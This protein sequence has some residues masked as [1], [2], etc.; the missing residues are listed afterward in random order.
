[1]EAQVLPRPITVGCNGALFGQTPQSVQDSDASSHHSI[2]LESFQRAKIQEINRNQRPTQASTLQNCFGSLPP[3][4]FSNPKPSFGRAQNPALILW[5]DF[6]GDGAPPYTHF[7]WVRNQ[8][9]RPGSGGE[10]RRLYALRLRPRGES[11]FA[12]PQEHEILEKHTRLSVYTP[13]LKARFVL[14]HD[15]RPD[16]TPTNPRRL[17]G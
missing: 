11:R 4:K 5:A 6:G 8:S 12:W 2:S 16:A 14:S 7:G 9:T 3:P 17:A 15:A 10:D 1:M 13:G